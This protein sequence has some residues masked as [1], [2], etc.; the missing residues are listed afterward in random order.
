MVS[1]DVGDLLDPEDASEQPVPVT[2]FEDLAS[3]VDNDRFSKARF[4]CREA[5]QNLQGIQHLAYYVNGVCGFTVDVLADTVRPIDRPASSIESRR[6]DYKLVGSQLSNIVNDLDRTLQK[7]RTGALI[8]TVLHASR[9]VIYCNSVVPNEYIIGSTFDTSA[10]PASGIPLPKL[11]GAKNMDVAIAELATALRRQLSLQSQDPGSWISTKPGDEAS[12]GQRPR[13]STGPDVSPYIESSEDDEVDNLFLAAVRPDDLHYL[14]RC[15]DGEVVFS[16]DQLGHRRLK[17][18]FTQ[19][20]VE[21]RRSFYRDFC[22]QLPVAIWM[23]GR[24]VGPAIGARLE[25]VVLDVEQGAIYYYRVR[26]GE[27]L[28]GVTIDQEQVAQA[29]ERIA[30]LALGCQ[31]R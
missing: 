22:R 7:V 14:A 15:H 16:V 18:F 21:E 24:M 31:R 26:S 2:P 10:L 29:D 8:R 17:S 3:R 25:R 9:G 19:I 20:T 4:L 5:V 11:V 6:S 13:L 27:Y 30:R 1:S 12:S 23:L 28:V